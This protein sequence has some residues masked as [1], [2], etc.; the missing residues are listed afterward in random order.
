MSTRGV[1][2]SGGGVWRVADEADYAKFAMVLKLV[3][4]ISIRSRKS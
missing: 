1:S 3:G 4:V 2:L